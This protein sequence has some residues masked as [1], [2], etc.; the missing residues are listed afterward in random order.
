MFAGDLQSR[1]AVLEDDIE[2]FKRRGDEY[3]QIC[4]TLEN[5]LEILWR[6]VVEVPVEV[7]IVKYVEKVCRGACRSARGE[8]RRGT[9]A[10]CRDTTG[11]P[12]ALA[13]RFIGGAVDGC[14]S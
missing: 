4:M 1:I 3:K 7:P 8:D 12:G 11:G 6:P 2:Y 14:R 13:C 5:Q 10:A 9:G